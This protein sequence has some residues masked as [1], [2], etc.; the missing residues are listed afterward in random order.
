MNKLLERMNDSLRQKETKKQPVAPVVST[1]D[2]MELY[3]SLLESQSPIECKFLSADSDGTHVG[4]DPTGVTLKMLKE[5]M[6]LNNYQ[7]RSGSMIGVNLSVVVK[8]IDEQNNTVY[9][10]MSRAKSTMADAINAEIKHDLAKGNPVRLVGRVI[11]VFPAANGRSGNAWV[12]LLDQDVIGN[13]DVRDWAPVYTRKLE[14]VCILGE[15]YEFDVVG[16]YTVHR[17]TGKTIW[18]LSR[19][20]ITPDP[21]SAL[22]VAFKEGNVMLVKA[23]EKPKDKSYFW[24]SSPLAPNINIM[25]NYPSDVQVVIGAYYKSKIDKLNIE[26]KFF[27][28]SPFAVCPINSA[29]AIDLKELA[30]DVAKSTS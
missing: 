7:R 5:D 14:D 3:R 22:P 23:E 21:W 15:T 16:K 20:Q 26:E 13:I 17:K 4:I 8:S 24:G 12:R 28:V 27:R 6:K 19:K 1:E 30:R 18:K 25:C 2:S 11:K 29:E 9:F 10:A